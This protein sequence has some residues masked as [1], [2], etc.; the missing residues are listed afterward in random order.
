VSNLELTTTHDEHEVSAERERRN[1]ILC[2]LYNV[3]IPAKLFQLAALVQ[4]LIGTS[5]FT[6]CRSVRGPNVS[7]QI[8]SCTLCAQ[9]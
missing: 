4:F 1:Q 9:V 8:S 6:R 2:A 3:A 5:P 7:V